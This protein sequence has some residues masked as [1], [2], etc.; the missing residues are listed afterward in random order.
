VLDS[1]GLII[2]KFVEGV[3]V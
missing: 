2:H 1:K 3:W